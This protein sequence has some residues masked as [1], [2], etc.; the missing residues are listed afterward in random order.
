M[1]P[2]MHQRPWFALFNRAYRFTE[3]IP[4]L[5]AWRVLADIAFEFKGSL[6]G[7]LGASA[8]IGAPIRTRLLASD[9]TPTAAALIEAPVF[10]VLV[11]RLDDQ[12]IDSVIQD[13]SWKHLPDVLRE[14]VDGAL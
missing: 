14:A 13:W 1:H 7:L 8:D 5:Q 3:S 2:L 12:P 6:L 11:S 10:L 9:A 4:E